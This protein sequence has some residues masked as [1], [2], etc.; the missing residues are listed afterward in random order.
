MVLLAVFLAG[1]EEGEQ[2]PVSELEGKRFLDAYRREG[3]DEAIAH[4]EPPLE[5]TLL[6]G[7]SGQGSCAGIRT[8][9][10]V[11]Y[12]SRFEIT[13]ITTVDFLTPRLPRRLLSFLS[14]PSRSV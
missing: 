12:V 13:A 6:A 3:T 4:K 11:C 9:T 5:A 7:S 2:S 10:G 8:S 1:C 14:K